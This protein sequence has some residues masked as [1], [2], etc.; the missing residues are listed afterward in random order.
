MDISSRATGNSNF[1]LKIM[2]RLRLGVVDDTDIG[3]G[4]TL[5]AMYS[6]KSDLTFS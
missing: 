3:R 6:R 2:K 1:L 5:L 4:V